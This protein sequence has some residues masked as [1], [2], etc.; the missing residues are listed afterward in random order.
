MKSCYE[1]TKGIEQEEVFGTI[2]ECNV[3]AFIC[4]YHWVCSA[5]DVAF[6]VLCVDHA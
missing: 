6:A 4:C 2:S 5:L 1:R 3:A